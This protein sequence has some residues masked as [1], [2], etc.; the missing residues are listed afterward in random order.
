MSCP[1]LCFQ[2]PGFI[3]LLNEYILERLLCVNTINEIKGMSNLELCLLSGVL[4]IVEHLV[5]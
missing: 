5:H 1:E 2:M 3:I 4:H